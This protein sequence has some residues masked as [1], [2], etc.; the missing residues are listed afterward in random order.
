[1]RTKI[2]WDS[3]V[4]NVIL[5][6][7]KKTRVSLKMVETRYYVLQ[8]YLKTNLKSAIVFCNRIQSNGRWLHAFG[9][10]LGVMLYDETCDSKSLKTIQKF[11]FEVVW[12]LGFRSHYAVVTYWY[13]RKSRRRLK[14]NVTTTYPKH[15][16][17][18][19]F[20]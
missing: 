18:N 16:K 20:F 5:V 15:L 2:I 3:L 14:L 10:D 12:N 11:I 1:M 6:S 9:R 8:L 17:S 7:R 13:T 4:T 19:F